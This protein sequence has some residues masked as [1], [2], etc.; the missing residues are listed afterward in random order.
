MIIL[1]QQGSIPFLVR[2]YL[3]YH[4]LRGSPGGSKILHRLFQLPFLRH[5]PIDEASFFRPSF[6]GSPVFGSDKLA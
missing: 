2:K 5:L 1:P 3:Q 4:R 6:G